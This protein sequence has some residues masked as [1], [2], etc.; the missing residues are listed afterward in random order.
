MTEAVHAHGALA[1]AELWYLGARSANH[2]TRLV[3][4]DVASLP[5]GVGKSRVRPARW[6]STDIRTSAAG[7]ATP[8]SAP[9]MRDS[10]S[11]MS[12]PRTAIWWRI[13]WI[14]GMNTRGDEYGGSLENRVRLLRELIEETKEAVGDRC[15]VAVRFKP[16][17]PIGA[18]GQPNHGERREMFAMLA[19]LPNL[20]DINIADYSLEMGVSRFTKE[21]AL[22]PYMRLDEIGDDEARGRGRPLHL[23]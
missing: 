21:G 10:I 19:E 18:D 5:N 14:P 1:G 20:W 4:M 15:A 6:T 7:T 13:S 23:A 12:M 3:S 8:R 9:A 11:S 16:P 17:R 2:F 22:E